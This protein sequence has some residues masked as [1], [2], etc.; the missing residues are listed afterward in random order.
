MEIV[1]Q[2]T[3]YVIQQFYPHIWEK[4]SLSNYDDTVDCY[5]EFFKE[6]VQRTANLVALWQT[7]GFC[8]G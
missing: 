5:V 6:V 4:Y 7:V 1:S 3:N 2:L 8:H